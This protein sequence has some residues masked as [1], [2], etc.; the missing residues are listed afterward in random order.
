MVSQEVFE[1]WK[2]KVEGDFEKQKNDFE[3]EKKAQEVVTAQLKQELGLAQEALTMSKNRE[4]EMKQIVQDLDDKFN[5]EVSARSTPVTPAKGYDQ[6]SMSGDKDDEK[7]DK[8]DIRG[9]DYKNNL[10]PGQWDGKP[11][12]FHSWHELF[13]AQLTALDPKWDDICG[14][15]REE[16]CLDMANKKNHTSI[17]VTSKVKES[18]LRR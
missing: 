18:L 1:A 11:E 2:L 14:A 15:L 12:A 6:Y 17:L 16:Y 10:K 13:M 7:D 5:V 9:F 3:A 8:L 4:D